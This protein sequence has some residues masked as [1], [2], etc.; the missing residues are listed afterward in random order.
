MV[1]IKKIIYIGFDGSN[2]AIKQNKFGKKVALTERFK[3]IKKYCNVL[4]KTYPEVQPIIF[5]DYGI[6]DLADDLTWLIEQIN[7][8]QIIQCEYGTKA[9]DCL[10]E[11]LKSAPMHAL[12]ISRDK[13]REY[14]KEIPSIYSNI[15]WR[16]DA[17]FNNC[18]L[19]VPEIRYQ[20]ENIIELG[21][22]GTRAIGSQLTG[23][24]IGEFLGGV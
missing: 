13:F 21:T 1:K 6:L 2:L 19:K 5:A 15:K 16:F 18:E 22:F 3:G 23:D 7:T 17:Y 20:I 9:D 4:S 8:W 10:I 24:M 11:L 14:R 12:I